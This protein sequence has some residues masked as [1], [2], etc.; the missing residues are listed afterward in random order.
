MFLN[1]NN[2]GKLFVDNALCE[3]IVG[4]SCQLLFN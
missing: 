1:E 3:K 4:T 2:R